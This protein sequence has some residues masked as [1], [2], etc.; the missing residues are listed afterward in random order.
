MVAAA[1]PQNKPVTAPPAKPTPPPTALNCLLASNV[2]A[3]RETDQQRKELAHQSLLFFLGR[4]DPRMTPPQLASALKQT[5]A[6]LNG[7]NAASLM[8]ECVTE[9]RA[10]ATMFD[11]VGRQLQQQ[12]Q[13][14]RK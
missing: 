1:P 2:F 12:Q 10:K 7:V 14:Q 3:Q 8:N 4:L 11:S 13:P 9:L 5:A 6:A